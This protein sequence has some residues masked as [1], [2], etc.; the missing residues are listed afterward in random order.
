ME[1]LK[2][3]S[4]RGLMLNIGLREGPSSGQYDL[5]NSHL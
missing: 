2:G 5:Q 1:V 4:K 3:A